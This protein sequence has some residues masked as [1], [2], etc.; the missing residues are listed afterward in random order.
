MTHVFRMRTVKFVF[1]CTHHLENKLLS[2]NAE[3]W[4]GVVVEIIEGCKQ[5]KVVGIFKEKKKIGLGNEGLCV[6][7][8]PTCWAC[9]LLQ[10]L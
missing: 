5:M 2:P 10:R 3:V 4:V 7:K 6:A 1:K 9:L 8:E